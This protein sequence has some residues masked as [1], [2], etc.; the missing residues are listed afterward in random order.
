MM[1]TP[2]RD[3]LLTVQALRAIA[4]LMVVAYHG[5]DEWGRHIAGQSADALWG[6]GSAGVDIFFVISGLVMTISAG[7][8]RS[9][10]NPAWVF[11]R[12]RL[13][14]IIPLYWVVTTAK[15]AAVLALPMLAMRTRL[16]L[17]YVVG[18]YLLLPVRDWTGEFRPVLPVGWTLTYEMMFYVLVAVALAWRLPILRVALPVLA[19]FAA[20]AFIDPGFANTI[21]VEFLYGV[22]IGMVWRVQQVQVLPMPQR[23]RLLATSSQPRPHTTA[24][25]L[26][27]AGFAAILLVPVTSGALRPLTWGLPAAA[28]VASAV[29]LE[30][31]LRPALPRWLLAAGDASYAIYLTH[32]FVVPL[33]FLIAMRA[34]LSADALLGV[35]MAAS[36]L[37]SLLV[38][39]ITHIWVEQPMLHWFRRRPA[40]P[41]VVVAG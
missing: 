35:T 11:L 2:R 13:T 5:L 23:E 18:S 38:G 34:G 24:V 10:P 3:D 15:I 37:V 36:L 16:D 33:V 14:R 30:P 32:G 8:V 21:V 31:L 41:P 4:A 9:R 22:A 25:V 26:L 17:P 40:A 27:V 28:I 19:I 12:Q 29:A 7:R 1:S 39:Q 6:N 20:A